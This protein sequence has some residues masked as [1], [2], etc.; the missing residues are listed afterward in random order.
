MPVRGE[1][2]VHGAPGATGGRARGGALR[3]VFAEILVPIEWILSLI[4][5][6][7]LQLFF[8]LPLI[9]PVGAIVSIMGSTGHGRI[10]PSAD[11]YGRGVQPLDEDGPWEDLPGITRAPCRPRFARSEDGR[12]VEVR[13]EG[14]DP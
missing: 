3:A 6:L 8:V 14:V 11:R 4:V 2:P 10:R 7:T 9:V 13:G 1:S 5:H 12:G